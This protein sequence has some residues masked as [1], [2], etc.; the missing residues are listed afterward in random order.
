MT[1]NELSRTAPLPTVRRLPQYLR[2]L[3]LLKV[4]GREVVSCTHIAEELKLDP[5]QIRKDL[6]VTGIIGRPKVG[7][8]VPELIAA[9]EE[10]LGWNNTV[11][12][13]LIGAGSLGRALLGYERF[14]ERN[15]L[16][17]VAA[18]DND[19]SKIGQTAGDKPIFPLEKFGDLARRMHIHLGIIAVPAAAAQ[20]T[21]NLMVGSGIRAIWNFAPV[22]LDLP[23]DVLIEN[24]DLSSSLAVLSSRLTALMKPTPQPEGGTH[25]AY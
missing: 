6:A 15:G 9:I 4:R 8:F 25:V 16:N 19:S 5:T 2:L 21:A 14:R 3:R 7:Y 10:F 13:L 12:A 1:D 17:I 24:V 11:D 23:E 20:E 18:F 22:S